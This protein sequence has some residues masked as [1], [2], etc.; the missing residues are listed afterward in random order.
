MA[1]IG[2]T[3][4]GRWKAYVARKGVR[5]SKR[6]DTK[7]A[8]QDWAAREEYLILNKEAVEGLQP[9]SDILKRYAREVS[10]ENKGHRWEVVRLEKIGR[11]KSVGFGSRIYLRPTSRIG[12]IDA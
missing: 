8:A 4:D 3:P 11:D 10:P 7:Q 5:K 1:S 2:R 12:G 9:L 6:F